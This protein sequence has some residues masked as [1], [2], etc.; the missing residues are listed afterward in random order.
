MTARTMNRPV[1]RLSWRVSQERRREYWIGTFFFMLFWLMPAIT[2]WLTAAAFAALTDN[3]IRRLYFVAAALL[4]AELI[5]LVIFSTAIVNFTKTWTFMRT[6]LQGNM[7][8]AQMVSGGP[9]AGPPVRSA[10]DAVSRFRD[11]ASDI[12]RFVDNWVDVAGGMMFAVIG[13]TIL[14][15]VNATATALAMLPMVLG[16]L[17]V[18]L[19][20]GTIVR[21]RRADRVATRAVGGMLGDVMAGTTSIKVNDATE[22]VLNRFQTLVDTRRQ[23]A[24]RDRT[25]NEAVFQFAGGAND[26][27]VALVLVVTAG[28]IAAGEFTL[29][30]IV[31]FLAYLP[32][33]A[34]FPRQVAR[35]ITRHRQSDVAFEGMEELVAGGDSDRL[36]RRIHLPVHRNPE[37]PIPFEIGAGYTVE[38][39]HS[40]T[41]HR[42][43]VRPEIDR[44]PLRRMEV[45]GLSVSFGANDVVNDISFAVAGQSFVVVTGRIGSGKTTLLRALLGLA[46]EATVSGS[47][48]WNGEEITD[49]GAFF[50]P[51]QCAFVSQIPQLLSDSLADN[52]LLG[53]HPVAD[54][55]TWL[56]PARGSAAVG[57]VPH[58]LPEAVRV[59]AMTGDVAMMPD[60]LA[61]LIGPRGLRLSGGQRQR[62]AAARALV[63]RPELLVV[64]DL[65]SALDVA[66]EFE[67]WENV[68]DAGIAVLA[69]S[70]RPKVLE[71]AD[72]I[73]DLG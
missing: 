14:A 38:E 57:E 30:E 71:R 53:S 37:E 24:V 19:L 26:V 50:V 8:Q 49:R 41:N 6:M 39:K 15:Q 12:A 70:H 56:H 47:V 64:D 59:A 20:D 68:A 54:S 1:I 35:F 28:S 66:T 4:V 51:P 60:G 36:A 73:I 55:N 45:E 9:D 44:Q 23:T 32:W 46:S 7:L 5:R 10:G 31:L 40:M 16:A 52:I 34:S 11:D 43:L 65:S 69:V 48:R 62:V 67:L 21:L 61:T 58:H 27:A 2:G 42:L 25:L 18:L 3:E 72:L 33:L 29:P 17:V 13:L 63:Q 22:P